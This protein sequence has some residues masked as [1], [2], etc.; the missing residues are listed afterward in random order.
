MVVKK[1][2]CSGI[3]LAINK[4]DPFTGQVLESIDAKRIFRGYE[5]P[6]FTVKQIHHNWFYL[7]KI[8]GEKRDIVFTCFWVKE[9]R[10]GNIGI[11]HVQ[12][13]KTFDAASIR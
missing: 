1:N 13:F 7:R 5:E 12:C 11:S 3:L 10:P 9:M 6:E 4:S 2:P 8:G